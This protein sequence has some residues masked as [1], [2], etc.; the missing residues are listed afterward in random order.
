[1]KKLFISQ[2]MKGK[3]DEEILR[4]REKAIKSAENTLEE[5]VEV[6]DSFFQNASADDRPLW[7]LGKSLELLATADVAYFA[8]GWEEARGCRIENTCAIEYGIDVIEDYTEYEGEVFVS[9]GVALE[10]LKSG[11]RMSRKGWNGKG[12]SVVYQKGYPQGIPCNKQTAEAWGMNEGDLFKC[13]PYLQIS[14]I[15]GSHAMWVPSVRDC[16]AEDWFVVI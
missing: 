11:C 16:L 6:I 10:A 15:D 1:M 4:V 7:F 14:T 2:P 12:L 13:E 5:P 9:F 3:T 8:K